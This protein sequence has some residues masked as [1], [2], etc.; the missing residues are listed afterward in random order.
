MV[1]PAVTD[2]GTGEGVA[3]RDRQGLVVR[4]RAGLLGTTVDIHLV[5]HYDHNHI[6][7]QQDKQGHMGGAKITGCPASRACRRSAQT[8]PTQRRRIYL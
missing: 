7:H 6:H 2:D 3:G 8:R 1:R 4:L 5:R